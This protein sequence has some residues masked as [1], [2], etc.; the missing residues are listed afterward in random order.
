MGLLRRRA[1][2]L[3][4]P[5]L[6]ALAGCQTLGE[7][8][9]RDRPEHPD[10]I[11]PQKVAPRR[12]PVEARIQLEKP[13][14]LE[15]GTRQRS[16][17]VY[18]LRR[19]WLFVG[20][21]GGKVFALDGDR[22][23]E[24]WVR[25]LGGAI[26]APLLLDGDRLYAASARGLLFALDAATGRTLWEKD[27]GLELGVRMVLADGRLIVPSLGDSL[28]A[29]EA[30][31][32]ELLWQHRNPSGS[33]LAIRGASVPAVAG[34]RLVA[35]FADG[36]V[37]AFSVA[38]GKQLWQRRHVT[39]T[40]F[41][42]VDAGPVIHGD[43][44][45]YATYAGRV[46]GLALADGETVWE[47]PGRHEGAVHLSLTGDRGGEKLL[48]LGSGEAV[49][50]RLVDGKVA[51]RAKLGEGDPT[52]AVLLGDELYIGASDGSFYGLSRQS[53]RPIA[54]FAPGKGVSAPASPAG[55]GL[56]VFSNGG[57]LYRLGR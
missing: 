33:K 34:D 17:P 39:N 1:G 19:D 46:R 4:L 31:T 5:L 3:A 13:A 7:V 15:V 56:W 55:R 2:L 40:P 29:V 41:D 18:D 37:A 38:D 12:L 30:E 20:T 44:A 21:R 57:Y 51:W 35:A 26:D 27:L 45:Y 43:V 14:P 11:E 53:G 8:A 52:E 16:G 48:V 42:D 36:T 10:G 32:G 25:D 49:A 54:F 50:L 9:R 24:R 47:A 6:L 23:S 28:T 22:L